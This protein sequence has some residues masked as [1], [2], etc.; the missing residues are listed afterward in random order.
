MSDFYRF[1][2]HPKLGWLKIEGTQDA[3][4]GINF[5]DE[6]PTQ[7]ENSSAVVDEAVKQLEEYFNG[8]RKSFELPLAFTG[9]DFQKSVWEILQTVPF[10]A[11]STYGQ[12][13]HQL[14]NPKSVRAVGQANGKNPISIVVPCHRIVGSNGKLTGYGGGLWRKKWLLAHEQ[15]DL[16]S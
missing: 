1:Y 14:N 7:P 10:G 6:A 15:T 12:I 3:I 16:F 5:L 8:Q 11:T 9:T 13:A 4:T 2:Q